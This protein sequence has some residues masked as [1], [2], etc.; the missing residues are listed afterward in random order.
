[1]GCQGLDRVGFQALGAEIERI[2]ERF[3]P[4]VLKLKRLKRAC[5]IG[6]NH[7]SLSDRIM[8]RYGDTPLGMVEAAGLGWEGRAEQ[9]EVMAQFK[10]ADRPQQQPSQPQVDVHEQ[11]ERIMSDPVASRFFE[12]NPIAL[13]DER[14]WELMDREMT[15]VAQR[16]GT[17]AQQFKAAEE[18]LRYAYANA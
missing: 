3:T 4:L 1:M 11:A 6:T 5:R 14:A 17:P 18:A 2:E 12:A 7:G 9:A 15:I 16:G 10:P 8:N 13:N